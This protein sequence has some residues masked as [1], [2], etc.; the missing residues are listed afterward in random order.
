ML[1]IGFGFFY[2]KFYYITGKKLF[3]FNFGRQEPPLLRQ[4]VYRQQQRPAQQ[5]LNYSPR[6]QQKISLVETQLQE[7]LKEAKKILGKK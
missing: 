2:Y 1:L 5:R 3:K 4:P 7:S 6:T